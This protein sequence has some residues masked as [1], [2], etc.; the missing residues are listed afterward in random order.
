MTASRFV[1]DSKE[2]VAAWVAER[3]GF[4]A[5]WGGYYAMGAEREGELV[6]GVVIQSWT[7]SNAVGH[8]AISKP[9][10]LLPDLFDH[11][12]LYVFG[13]LKLGRLTVFVDADNEKSLRLTTHLGFVDEAVMKAAGDG[14]V[15]I[16]VRVL[17]PE[18]YRKGKR[19]G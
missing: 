2:R 18:N 8:L 11:V 17:W 4:L 16:H 14:G 7:N 19:H 5:P 3:V 15:D 12:V 6:C 1:F 9:T 13:Q 10:R